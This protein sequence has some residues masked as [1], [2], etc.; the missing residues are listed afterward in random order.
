MLGLVGEGPG[1]DTARDVTADVTLAV[2]GA[3]DWS[4]GAR[5]GAMARSMGPWTLVVRFRRVT[6]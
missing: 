1:G 4:R 2:L 5:P 6:P 3:G